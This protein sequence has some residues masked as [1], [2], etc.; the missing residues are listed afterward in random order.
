MFAQTHHVSMRHVAPVRVELGTRTLFNLLGPLSNPAGVERQLIGV[1]SGT[2]SEPLTRVLQE[3]GSRKIW[4]VHGSDG[5]DEITTTG[6]TEVVALE[7]GTIRRF[8]L[9]PR[10]VGI[11]LAAADD[12]RG[13][14][15]AHNAAAF[16]AVLDGARTPYRDIAVLNAAAALVVA[17]AAANPAEG[18][19]RAAQALD[20]GAARGTLERLVAAS[21]A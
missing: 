10:E 16:R 2:W 5:L 8:T 6:P 12:L 19:A 3:L 13:A 17:D 1:F 14:D 9:D 7:D 21:N 20:S 18:A 15:P 4:T 11:P